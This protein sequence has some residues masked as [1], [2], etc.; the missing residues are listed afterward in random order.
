ML[1][2]LP[3]SRALQ[4]ESGCHGGEWRAEVDVPLME[5][6]EQYDVEIIYSGNVIRSWR[7]NVPTQLYTAAEQTADFG[8]IPSDF[9]V[10]IYQLSSLVGRG[11]VAETI[12]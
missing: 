3:D 8:S 1:A 9:T 12:L 5:T 11:Q 7:V 2:V 4:Y 6:T 10:R